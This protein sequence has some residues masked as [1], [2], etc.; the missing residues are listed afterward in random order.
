MFSCQVL[1]LPSSMTTPTP[2]ISIVT[3][4]YNSAETIKDTF[5]SVANQT[6]GNVEHIL[7]DGASKDETLSIAKTYGQHL[8]KVV[9][10]PDKGIYDAMNK[11][12]AATSGEIVGIL[13]SDDFYASNEVLSL[14]ANAFT[15]PNID[16]VYGDLYYVDP[17]D[18]SVIK[19][20]WVSGE[21]HRQDFLNGWMPPHPTFFVRKKH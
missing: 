4:A 18:T 15:D 10:E 20:N 9:S 12:V 6:Y 3:A 16:C 2:K 11:G 19:R 1:S 7:I 5:S 13:N 14:V 8:A 21:Y 17:A